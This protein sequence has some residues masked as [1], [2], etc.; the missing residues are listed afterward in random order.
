M[1]YDHKSDRRSWV[2]YSVLNIVRSEHWGSSCISLDLHIESWT[3]ENS[4]IRARIHPI[5]QFLGMS[6]LRSSKPSRTLNWRSLTDGLRVNVV[7]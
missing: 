5:Q 4:M 2:L 6:V 1:V 3:G 7:G